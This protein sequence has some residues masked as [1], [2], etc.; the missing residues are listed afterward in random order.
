MSSSD[1][2]HRPEAPQD[3]EIH[4]L[5][6]EYT[7]DDLRAK[8]LH[9]DPV[10]QFKLWFQQALDRQVPEPTAMTL[11]TADTEGQPSL[12]T[13][14]L[15]E[16][17]GEDFVFYT[18]YESRKGRELAANPKAALLFFWPQLERQVRIEGIVQRDSQ[19]AAE[20]YFKS[21]PRGSRL[22]A[23]ASPQSRPL[24]NRRELEEAFAAVEERF[25]DGE[26]PLPSHWG[27]YRLTPTALEFWQ[28][29]PSRLH[30][31]F[32]YSRDADGWSLRRLAP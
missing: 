4:D 2:T 1:P 22:G 3:L 24:K 16:V 7:R 17:E 10:E 14:L 11:A 27:G 20:A 32:L 5:R 9:P 25:A 26:V 31:R 18:N 19:E 28:G 8:D 23:W 13:V 6:S 12:R 21:R 15:K 30:D 29:R